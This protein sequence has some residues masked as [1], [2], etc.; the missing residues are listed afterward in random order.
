[1][2]CVQRNKNR[3]CFYGWS[4][5]FKCFQV[6]VCDRYM[7]SVRYKMLRIGSNFNELG[8]IYLKLIIIKLSK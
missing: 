8:D 3:K 1:M 7:L 6:Q 4:F 5:K 2:K